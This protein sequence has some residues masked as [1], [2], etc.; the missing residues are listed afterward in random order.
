MNSDMSES[1]PSHSQRSHTVGDVSPQ[2]RPLDGAFRGR[3]ILVTGHTG[4]KGSWLS[5]WL[6][7]LG[8]RVS[9]IALDPPTEPSL[10]AAAG[11]AD[12]LEHD[13]RR[14][15][16]DQDGLLEAV[17]ELRPEVIFHLAAQPIV[18]K[19][20]SQSAE[21]FEV[22]VMGSVN[23]FE[24]ARQVDSVVVLIHV[25]SD[26]CYRTNPSGGPYG[27]DDPLGGD[28]PYSASKAAAELAL[29]AYAGTFFERAGRPLWA[30]VRAGNVIGG[31]DWAEDRII[32]DAARALARGQPVKVRN[33]VHVRPWQ[34]VLDALY[35][36]LLVA[37]SLLASRRDLQGAWNFG[38]DH[39][40]ERTVEDLVKTFLSAW[41]EGS[42][43]AASEGVSAPETGKLVLDSAKAGR[44]LQW[45]PQWPFEEAVGRT[46][47]WYRDFYGKKGAALELCRRDIHHFTTA[48]AASE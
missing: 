14:D 12:F 40:A 2:V 42:W 37:A 23:L 10:Y 21:T 22:N 45:T 25:S 1:K 33:P 46:A 17:R 43:E 6:R 29:Q 41:G 27:E 38:P 16:R 36:Y 11:L 13:L 35:G 30:S 24:C 15:I 39:N 31:G 8:A 19:A 47:R 28:E 34:H 18:R 3:R 48:V 9:G 4:F 5:L 20:F 32:P 7:E 44:L 26:K